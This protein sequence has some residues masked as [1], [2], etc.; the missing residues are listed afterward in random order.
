MPRRVAITGAAGRLGSQLVLAFG[1]AGD[2][3][4]PLSRPDFDITRESD[5]TEMV[6]WKPDVVVNAAAWTDVDGCARDPMAAKRINGRAAG[7]V[8]AAAASANAVVIQISTNEVF[9]GGREAGYDEEDEP[10]PINAYGASKLLGE[11]LAADANPRHLIVRSAWLFGPSGS[12]FAT[13]ILHA[14]REAHRAGR[15]LPVVSDEWGNPTW[16]P[17]LANSMVTILGDPDLMR[18]GILHLAGLPPVSRHGWAQVLIDAAGLAVSLDP[19]PSHQFRRASRPPLRAVL[20]TSRP[21]A[22]DLWDDW[23][24]YSARIAATIGNSPAMHSPPGA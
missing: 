22:V 13:K 17:S 18:P 10:A 9:D 23:Q 21:R 11:R 4:L 19:I 14:A 6:R 16:M 2:H 3:V 15:S 20:R 1:R 24:P 8:A 5:L 7:A 12:S